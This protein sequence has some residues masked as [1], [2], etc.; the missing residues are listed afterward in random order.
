MNIKDASLSLNLLA[1]IMDGLPIGNAWNVSKT[2]N[3]MS[4]ELYGFGASD[5]LAS[6]TGCVA[7]EWEEPKG[8]ATRRF[9]TLKVVV[10]GVVWSALQVD[11]ESKRVPQ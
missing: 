5:Y 6:Q 11:L 8:L 1:S 10:D 9:R 2:P 7:G 3:G 4:V